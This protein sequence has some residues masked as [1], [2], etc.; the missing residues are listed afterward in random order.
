[1][2]N[3]L[4]YQMA[5]HSVTASYIRSAL[6]KK[7]KDEIKKALYKNVKP[8]N[9]QKLLETIAKL[10]QP[11]RKKIGI[12]SIITYNFDDL[13]ERHS[14]R[15]GVEYKSLYREADYEEPTKIPIYHVHGFI[16]QRRKKNIQI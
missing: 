1:M 3:Q 15:K 2:V 10:A 14:E 6:G 12:E 5:H 9:E 11:R 4:A 13:F 16:P 7:F 8:I